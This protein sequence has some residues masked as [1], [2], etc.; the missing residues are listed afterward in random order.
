M[1]SVVSCNTV[2]S[3]VREARDHGKAITFGTQWRVHLCV[4]VI[5]PD[6]FVSEGEV[7]GSN[8]TCYVQPLLLCDANHLK[9]A[10]C[11]NVLYMKMWTQSF[12]T[13]DLTKKL[14][15]ALDDT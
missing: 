7:V 4:R 10:C 6:R 3:S 13:F 11:R 14:D 8:F 9:G 1:R 2:D 5:V 12:N 15:V